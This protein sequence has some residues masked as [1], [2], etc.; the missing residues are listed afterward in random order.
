MAQGAVTAHIA[1]IVFSLYLPDILFR[2]RQRDRLFWPK[3]F[4]SRVCPVRHIQFE[5]YGHG[6]SNRSQR[7]IVRMMTV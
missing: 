5:K 6:P 3:F 1:L 2:D 4:R 7:A